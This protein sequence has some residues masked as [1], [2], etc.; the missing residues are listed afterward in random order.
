[1]RELIIDISS[2]GACQSLHMD[3]FDLEFLGNKKITRA[4]EIVFNNDTQLWDV[5]LPEQGFNIS[6]RGFKSYE[7]A[8]DFEIAWLQQCR[9]LQIDPYTAEGEGIAI[10]CRYGIW[11]EIW[12]Q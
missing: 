4:S 2:S 9:K 10:D 1:M 6:T 7:N 5:F 8:K 11:G 3:D 12:K